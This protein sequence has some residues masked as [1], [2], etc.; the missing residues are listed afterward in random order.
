ME[1]KIHQAT[2]FFLQECL[3]EDLQEMLQGA[4]FRNPNPNGADYIPMQVFEQNLPIPQADTAE[5][6]STAIDYDD[7][8]YADPV[9]N[10]PWAVVKLDSGEIPGPNA[11]QRVVTA[12]CFGIYNPDAANDGHKDLLN[13]IQEVYARFSNRPILAKSFRCLLDF[14]W[15]IQRE[16]T[17]PYFFGA[18]SMSFEMHGMKQESEF[19]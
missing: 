5:L 10:C 7:G 16:D 3:V 18:I 13:L 6:E 1:S 17:F 14:E 8:M 4:L 19:T 12:V 9:Y 2:P 15:S 11:K